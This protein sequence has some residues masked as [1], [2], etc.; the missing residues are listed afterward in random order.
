VSFI[1]SEGN[2]PEFETT[3]LTAQTANVI[4]PTASSV[5]LRNPH[6]T[7]SPNRV[8][9]DSGEDNGSFSMPLGQF[10]RTFSR[11]DLGVV[12]NDGA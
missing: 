10:L 3:P 6:V 4:D 5:M 11:V 1:D 12:R 9:H 8:G 7:G 2:T